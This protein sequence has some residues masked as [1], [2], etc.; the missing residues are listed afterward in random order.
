MLGEDLQYL[1]YKVIVDL[2]S[3][4]GDLEKNVFAD[5]PQSQLQVSLGRKPTVAMTTLKIS[6]S[7]VLCPGSLG[8]DVQDV[9]VSQMLHSYVMSLPGSTV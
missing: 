3:S 1:L 9:Y 7:T 4:S 8:E 2:F 6:S 5:Q